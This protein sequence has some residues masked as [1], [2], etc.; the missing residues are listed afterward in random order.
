MSSIIQQ[1]TNIETQRIMILA[2]NAE[3]KRLEEEKNVQY[4]NN[5]EAQRKIILA[6]IAEKMIL[7]TNTR[8]RKDIER[9]II[10]NNIK[11]KQEEKNKKEIEIEI[12]RQENIRVQNDIYKINNEIVSLEA[13]LEASLQIK[14]VDVKIEQ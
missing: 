7:D 3:K 5:V 4:N 2:E 1:D 11:I 8:I 10:S 14:L 13:S 6:E 12:Y 9:Q